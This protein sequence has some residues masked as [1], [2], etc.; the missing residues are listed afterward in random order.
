M[1]KTTLPRVLNATALVLAPL[2]AIIR[3]LFG[4]AIVTLP[5]TGEGLALIAATL[6][7][8]VSAVALF[9]LT[10]ITHSQEVHRGQSLR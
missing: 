3:A 5:R 10:S 1:M 9:I 7:A 4:V 2:V 6:C 8:L